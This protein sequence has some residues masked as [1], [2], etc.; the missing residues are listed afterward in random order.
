MSRPIM[1]IRCVHILVVEDNDDTREGITEYLRAKGHQ[2]SSAANGREAL[3]ALS[4][5]PRPCVVLLDWVMPVMGGEELLRLLELQ[6]ALEGVTVVA[7]TARNTL[8]ED[9]P[10]RAV[11]SKPLDLSRLMRVVG[12]V[13]A[14]PAA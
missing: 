10:L 4:Q 3:L 1:G 13:A 8:P 11:V 14:R 6:Q 7:V 12:E 9:V 2:V 5:L